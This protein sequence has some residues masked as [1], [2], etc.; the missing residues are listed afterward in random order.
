MF[1]FWGKIAC[2]DLRDEPNT[3]VRSRN[4]SSVYLFLTIY[5]ILQTLVSFSFICSK[6]L[7]LEKAVKLIYTQQH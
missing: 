2:N 4:L 5:N 1:S 7:F 6:L 3:F